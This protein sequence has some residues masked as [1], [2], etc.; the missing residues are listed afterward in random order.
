[1]A[2]TE[3]RPP[4]DEHDPPRRA[5]ARGASPWWLR[6][7]CQDLVLF[8]GVAAALAI[9][10]A[11]TLRFGFS[12][13]TIQVWDETV[14]FGVLTLVL[15]VVWVFVMLLS[16]AYSSDVVGA[17]STE[18]ERVINGGIRFLA[19]I[20][21][22]AYASKQDLA[23]GFV[24]VLLPAV[25]VC[26]VVGRW[27]ARRWLHRHRAAGRMCR[28]V[29]VTGN[30]A[31]VVRLARHLAASPEAGYRVV[32]AC[33]DGTGELEVAG[34]VVPVLGGR[35]DVVA[36]A[37]LLDAE[38]VA[39]AGEYKDDAALLRLARELEGTG[40]ELV[41]APALTEVSGPRMSMR[42]IASLP[43]VKI[44]EPQFRGPRRIVKEV[45]D[46][47][48]GVILVVVLSPALLVLALAVRCTSRGPVL[49]RQ[50][51]VGLGGTT[52]SML[53]F[54][55]M[56]VDAE[57]RLGDLLEH[58]DHDGV[59]FKMRDDPRVT[60][61]G[62]FLRR[63]SLDE[64]PQL[65]HVVSGRMS[66]VGPRPPL[67]SEVERYEGDVVRRL[68][69]KPGL[70]GLWQVSGRADLPWEEAVRLDLYYV[71]HWSLALDAAI[72]GKT[73]VAVFRGRGAY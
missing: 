39:V 12:E 19:L 36:V 68:L 64:L 31:S 35:I 18:Y 24:A 57:D 62:R 5:R 13:S 51:R 41:V 23:R 55:T 2:I 32:G 37:E 30:R 48:G 11:Y 63:F 33:V 56:V 50:E 60:R 15:V 28:R 43:L 71:Q 69:V 40:I 44:E 52:F 16:G 8:D 54:R 70:T 73:V 66:L 47:L 49:F 34:E 21:I 25:I 6:R 65:L 20:A 29:V 45:L 7:Y 9:A 67:P 10:F 4:H 58:N 1:M 27:L 22:V 59:L 3:R 72:L 46:R 38:V 53:K 17:G 42:P 14:P 26:T 61:V